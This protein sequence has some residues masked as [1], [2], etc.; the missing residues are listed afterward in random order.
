LAGS[1]EQS[2]YEITRL[3]NYKI[4]MASFSSTRPSPRRLRRGEDGYVLLTLLL[5]FALMAIV[6]TGV[7]TEISFEIRRDR[8]QEMVHRGVQ[9]TR[10]I[11]A[12]YKKLGRYPTRLEDLE[13]TNNLRYLRKR[14]KDPLNCRNSKCQDFKLLHFGDPGVSMGGSFGGGTIPGAT[15]AAS[16][17]GLSG[18]GPSSSGFGGSSFGS[19]GS[20]G[21][22]FGGSGV[23]SSGVFSQSSG[24]GGNSNSQTASGQQGTSS[25][26]GS[27]PTDASAQVVPGTAQGNTGSSSQQV[28]GGGPIVGVA[29]ISKDKTIREFNKKRKYNE[30]Q[31]IYDPTADR[32]GLIT[33][34][35]QPALQNFSAQQG[36]GTPAGQMGQGQPGSSS[37][38]SSGFGQSSGFGNN[39]TSGAPP[40]PVQ[41]PANPPQ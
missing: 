21:S 14:Y 29:S 13:N 11:R 9:Y 25:A 26:P 41:T 23:N 34:P 15:P 28:F 1:P 5:V 24:F 16:P 7:I 30:W 39:S 12:Y 20:S 19:S 33:T 6:A 22:A 38:F 32:G 37:S 4:L 17:G 31:F 2:N 36:I 40:S 8:E 18:S 3:S 10:A 27:D 35:Y